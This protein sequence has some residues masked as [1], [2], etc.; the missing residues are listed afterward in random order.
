MFSNFDVI[1]VGSGFFG[2]TIAEKINSE[3]SLKVAVI[4]SRNHIGGNAY[5]QIDDSTGIEYHKYGSHIFH[6]SSQKI[7]EYCNKFAKFNDYRHKVFT[8]HNGKMYSLPINLLTINQF[9]EQ[10][11][12]PEAAKNKIRGVVRDV[13]ETEDLNFEKKAI[14]LVGIELYEAFIK[15]Y[16]WKQWQ[17]D[18]KSLPASILTRLPFRFNYNLDYFDDKYQGIPLNG[19]TEWIKKLLSKSN[20]FLNTDYFSIKPYLENNKIVIYTGPIDKYFN[21]KFGELSWRTLDFELVQKNVSDYQGN[22]VINYAD[23]DVGYTR[24]HEFRHLHPE[25]NYQDKSTLVMYEES[26]FATKID[27][28]YYPVNSNADRSKLIE[29]RKLISSE[30]NVFFGGRLGSYQ[31]LDMHMAIGSALNMY[32]NEIKPK[33]KEMNMF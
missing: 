26:R 33:L 3:T 16:T 14:S 5:S 18:P 7:W 8:K 6:T 22:S 32:E 11:L 13:D 9:Y 17:T 28:P 10:S 21:Y 12:S 31:Y 1:I 24:I 4:E 27:E 19:Y 30:K 23:L 20:V 29:Y 15:N 25:R 2:A